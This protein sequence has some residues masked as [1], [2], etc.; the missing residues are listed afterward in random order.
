MTDKEYIQVVQ[1]IL[2]GEELEILFCTFT[3]D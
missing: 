1:W 2:G 3:V